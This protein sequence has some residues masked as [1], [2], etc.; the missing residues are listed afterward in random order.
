M[1]ASPP[2]PATEAHAAS[3]FY[4]RSGQLKNARQAP[5]ASLGAS[6]HYDPRSDAHDARFL[7]DFLETFAPASDERGSGRKP[8]SLLFWSC[9]RRDCSGYNY[10]AAISNPG[11]HVSLEVGRRKSIKVE[12]LETRVESAWF[13]SFKPK[14]DALLSSVAF[15]CNLRPYIEDACKPVSRCSTTGEYMT[16][17]QS[18]RNQECGGTCNHPDRVGPG[19]HCSP[20]HRIQLADFGIS[21]SALSADA[22]PATVYGHSTWRRP[23]RADR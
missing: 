4:Q 5:G 6:E 19:R 7:G 10:P 18:T 3:D 8:R 13:Q 20:R 11:K 22:L 1:I 23:S 9:S 21:L 15:N 12:C 17:W 2:P 14:Y 16:R